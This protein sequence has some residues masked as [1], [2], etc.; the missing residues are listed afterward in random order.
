MHHVL[1]IG[2]CESNDR[3]FVYEE[4]YAKGLTG[5]F[6]MRGCKFVAKPLVANEKL[7]KKMEVMK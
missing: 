3:I 1:G 5:K 4:K 7:Q 2:V 6:G